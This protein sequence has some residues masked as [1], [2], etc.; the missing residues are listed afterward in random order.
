L[1]LV[2]CPDILAIFVNQ[3]LQMNRR[4]FMKSAGA[5]TLAVN[6]YLSPAIIRLLSS[7]DRF[8]LSL[9]EENDR[10]IPDLLKR[11]NLNENSPYYGGVPDRYGI[12]TAGGTA[13]LIEIITC[14]FIHPASRYHL[15]DKLILPLV[16][17]ARYMTNTQH[18]DGTIDLHTTNFHSTPDTAF[19][20]EHICATCKILLTNLDF[21]NTD[22]YEHLKEFILRGGDALSVGGIHTPNHRWVVCMALARI[23]ELFPNQKYMRRINEWLDEKIDIDPDGQFTEKSSSIYSPLTDRCLIT[24]ARLTGKKELYEPVRKNLTMTFYYVHADGEVVTE[25][26]RRQDKYKKGSMAPYYYPYRYMALYD[27]N[28]QYAAMT[29]WIQETAGSKLTGNLFHFLEDNSFQN[30]LPSPKNLP[31]NYSKFF[32]HSQLVRIRRGDISATIL[33][34]NHTVFS[35]HKGKAALESLR[36]A[37]AF[38]G[39]GQFM[40]NHLEKKDASYTLYQDLRGPYYQP[41]PKDKLPD[42]GDWSKMP[43]SLRPQSEI[44]RQRTVINIIE[45]NGKF[46]INI[47]IKGTDYVPV[48]IEL[49]F[50]KGGQFSSVKELEKIPD[51]FILDDNFGEYTFQNQKIRFGPG[52]FQHSWT[53]LRGALP[54]L[55]A[56]SVYI[57]GFTPFKKTFWIE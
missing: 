33:A 13:K 3:E 44:Q 45:K 46:E 10:Q 5:G 31:T 30:N 49:G 22:V 52:E 40:G 53:Q 34:Q 38:F 25:A 17:A 32:K 35:F 54:K 43:R 4:T 47:E 21:P 23:N 39:K 16:H 29:R 37:S 51:A 50:R 6:Y 55:D 12:H 27:Q 28:G 41:F 14:A 48:A 24:I 1:P 42:D 57:T 2:T 7:N 19:V 15:S 56:L 26:S 36:V 8:Y 9:I 18:Q 11:Q 20:L